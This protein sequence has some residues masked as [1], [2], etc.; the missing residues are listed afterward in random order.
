M[1]EVCLSRLHTHL[2]HE[3]ESS[4][5]FHCSKKSIVMDGI[6]VVAGVGCVAVQAVFHPLCT[7]SMSFIWLKKSPQPA[8]LCP[9]QEA[10]PQNN[11]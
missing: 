9:G 10:G 7:P 1:R 3:G 11:Q 8:V 5:E 2:I 4:R 6:L